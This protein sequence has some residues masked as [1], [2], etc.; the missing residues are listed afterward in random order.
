MKLDQK[1]QIKKSTSKLVS[2]P[3]SKNKAL[4]ASRKLTNSTKG[5]VINHHHQRPVRVEL[6]N[7]TVAVAVETNEYSLFK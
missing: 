5:G 3:I 4:K 1:E 2:A 7:T 6:Q